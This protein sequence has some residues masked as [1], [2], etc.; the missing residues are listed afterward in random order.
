[1]ATKRDIRFSIGALDI[2]TVITA[3]TEKKFIKINVPGNVQEIELVRILYSV[4]CVT[5]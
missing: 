2:N 4:I 1:M 5:L 3:R